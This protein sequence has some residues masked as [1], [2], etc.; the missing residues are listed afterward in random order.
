MPLASVSGANGTSMTCVKS[1]WRGC[2]IVAS[3]SSAK[4]HAPVEQLPRLPP[5]LRPRIARVSNRHLGHLE[6]RESQSTGRASKIYQSSVA[7]P[8]AGRKMQS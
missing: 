5:E 8:G 7:G 1:T 6:S 4:S 3:G 2:A